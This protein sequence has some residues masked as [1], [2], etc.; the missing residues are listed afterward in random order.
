MT[1][2]AMPI[3]KLKFYFKN[4]SGFTVVELLTTVSI[5][6]MIAILLVLI[7]AKTINIERRAFAAQVVQ[8]NALAVFELMAKDIR[9]G[10]IQSSNV[11]CTSVP[12]VNSLDLRIYP[13]AVGID[14]SYSLNDDGK[15]IKVENGLT[16]QLSTDDVVFESLG[17]CIAGSSYPDNL[18]PKVTTMAKIRSAKISDVFVRIQTTMVSRDIL[19]EFQN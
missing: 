1:K 16:Y 11:D 19:D 17:F 9:V 12:P 3:G 13:D 6:S 2:N 5:F 7:F 18:S 14:V 4:Q 10:S 15:V 8:E